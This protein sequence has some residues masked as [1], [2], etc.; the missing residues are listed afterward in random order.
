V[1]EQLQEVFGSSNFLF[2]TMSVSAEIIELE[3]DGR[4]VVTNG[5]AV[6]GIFGNGA[7]FM[8]GNSTSFENKAP[9][10]VR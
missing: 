4:I 8:N 10:Q 7:V 5:D 2:E 6:F 3:K 9:R 1:R